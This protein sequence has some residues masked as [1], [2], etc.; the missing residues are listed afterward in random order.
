MSILDWIKILKD[1]NQ[2]EKNNLALLCQER[3]IPAWELLFKEGDL[4]NSMYLLKSW[5]F[6]VFTNKNNE[7]IILWYIKSEDILWEMAIFEHHKHRMASARATKDT[8]VIILLEFALQEIVNKH[9]EILEK[10][11]KIIEERRKENKEVL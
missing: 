7:E 3:F 8:I 11:K 5:E 10:I 9:P 4:S 1:L 2:E 6:E